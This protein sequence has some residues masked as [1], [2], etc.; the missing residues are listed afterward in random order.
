MF[1]DNFVR[2]IGTVLVL[3][4]LLLVAVVAGLVPEGNQSS[5]LTALIAMI[6]GAVGMLMMLGCFQTPATPNA[7]GGWTEVGRQPHPEGGDVITYQS[8]S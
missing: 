2:L 3:G 7:R 5:V 1:T 4:A 6:V 8:A